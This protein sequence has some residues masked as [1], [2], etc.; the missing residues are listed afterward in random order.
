MRRRTHQVGC[1]HPPSW[2]Y[3]LYLGHQWPTQGWPKTWMLGMGR[4]KMRKR[5]ISGSCLYL[6]YLAWAHKRPGGQ[7]SHLMPS[8]LAS[9]FPQPANIPRSSSVK[10]SVSRN[11]VFPWTGNLYMTSAL[12]SVRPSAHSVLLSTLEF[13]S[14]PFPVVDNQ[15]RNIYIEPCNLHLWA[16]MLRKRSWVAPW[17]GQLESLRCIKL[18]RTSCRKRCCS[19]STLPL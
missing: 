15:Q 3:Q 17:A 9:I 10:V 13:F 1:C 16:M 4:R 7:K 19:C 12:T 5:L 18:F 11:S 6:Q 2:L 8:T 14:L